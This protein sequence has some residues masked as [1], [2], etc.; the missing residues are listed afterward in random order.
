M[1][2]TSPGDL[3]TVAGDGPKLDGIVFDT[4]SAT[5]VVV[6]VVDRGR[7]PVFR[8]VHP[9]TLSERAAEGADDRALRLLIRRTPPPTRG[10]ARGAGGAGQGRSGHTRTAMHRTTGK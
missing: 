7:G 5:K 8:T 10:G 3:V 9:R 4:P 1:E 2:T 6:A